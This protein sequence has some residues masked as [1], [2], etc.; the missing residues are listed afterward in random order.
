MHFFDVWFAC[1]VL[2]KV[3]AIAGCTFNCPVDTFFKILDPN[4]YTGSTEEW[5]DECAQ[6]LSKDLTP[7]SDGK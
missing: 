3:L 5:L 2:Y 4:I 1:I 6:G 7:K